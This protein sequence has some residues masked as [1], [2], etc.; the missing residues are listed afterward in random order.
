MNK[1]QEQIK[2]QDALALA[3]W[4]QPYSEL[5]T[6]N[7]RRIRWALEEGWRPSQQST[8]DTK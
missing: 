3:M 7:K 6:W 4:G 5:E 1:R 2:L 8:E